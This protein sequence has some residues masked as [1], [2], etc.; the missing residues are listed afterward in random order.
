MLKP[1]IFAKIFTTDLELINMVIPSLRIFMSMSLLF[2]IQIACQ[3]TFIALDNAKTSIFLALLRKVILLIPLIYILPLFLENKVN[4]VF[5]AEPIA[6]TLSVI[7]TSIVSY[8]S[9]K[10]LFNEK[11]KPYHNTLKKE[12]EKI[13]V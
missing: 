13:V 1:S 10:K 11:S 7:I 8:I 2:S 5:I 4:A 9:F 6:D 3:Q 12:D